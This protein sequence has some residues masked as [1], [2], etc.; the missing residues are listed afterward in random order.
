MKTE[1][2]NDYKHATEQYFDQSKGSWFKPQQVIEGWKEALQ[3][4]HQGDAWR[5][6]TPSDLGYRDN[7]VRV[8]DLELLNVSGVWDMGAVKRDIKEAHLNEIT[9]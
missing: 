9:K 7:R 8:F 3:L 6:Y 4:M 1:Y 5:I 2:G